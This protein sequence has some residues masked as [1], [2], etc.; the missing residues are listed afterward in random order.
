MLRDS[1]TYGYDPRSFGRALRGRQGWLCLLAERAGVELDR[2]ARTG[3]PHRDYQLSR[4]AFQLTRAGAGCADGDAR[5]ER[6]I[7]G[8][9]LHGGGRDGAMEVF[10]EYAAP[11]GACGGAD[12]AVS[13]LAMRP[14]AWVNERRLIHESAAWRSSTAGWPRGWAWT[15]CAP[16]RPGSLTLTAYT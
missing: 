16:E 13:L 7:D 11:A 15:S 3:G 5:R 12:T 14:G 1:N 4:A 9:G 6:P 10:L 8:A 2:A